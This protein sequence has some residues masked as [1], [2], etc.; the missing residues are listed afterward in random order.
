[1]GTTPG[2]KLP[3]RASEYFLRQGAVAITD[4]PVGIHNLPIT[5]SDCIV[6]GNDYPHDEGTFPNS[7]RV[8]D[9]MRESVEPEP[10]AKILSGNA[11]RLYDFDLDYLAA[12]PV[13]A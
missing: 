7:R 8:I 6:W 4:D 11:A 5:G 9:A 13:P 3:L 10:L 1:M 2:R 12:N